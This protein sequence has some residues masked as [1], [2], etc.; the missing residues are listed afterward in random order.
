LKGIFLI[1]DQVTF[2]TTKMTRSRQQRTSD[3]QAI[4]KLVPELVAKKINIVL[5]DQRVFMGEL[6]RFDQ[7][8]VTLKNMRAK[9]VMVDFTT[10][11]ELYFETL[12]IC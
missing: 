5:N 11:T 1:F 6:L 4:Q 12:V 9:N 8:G 10:I 7:R 3:P 2:S